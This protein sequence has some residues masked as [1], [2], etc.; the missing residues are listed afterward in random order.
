MAALTLKD[1]QQTAL[2][3]FAFPLR[4]YYEDTDSGG[5]IYHGQYLRFLERGRTEW[6]RHLGFSNL[7]LERKYKMLWVVTEA[8]LNYLKPARL[9]DQLEVTVAIDNLA[10]VRVGFAQEIRRGDEVL[11]KARVVV[12]CVAA[13]SFKPIELP[14]EV[15][16][17][18]EAAA[19]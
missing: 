17:K 19:R 8:T 15:R 16:R 4:T 12:A 13:D 11:L 14:Q 18:M 7:E 10:R 6:L 3:T 5:V 9:D 2:F 1:A